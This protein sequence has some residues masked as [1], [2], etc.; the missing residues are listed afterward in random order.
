VARYVALLR[1]INVGG[2]NKVTMA[3]L[4]RV[5]EG[6]GHTAVRTYLQSGNVVFSSDAPRRTLEADVERLLDVEL[7][8]PV[9]VVVR[10]AGELRQV[11]AGAPDGFGAAAVHSDVVFLRSPLTPAA[12][13]RA[14]RL[15][16]GVDRAWPGRGVLYFTRLSAARSRSRMNSIVG[17]PEYRLMTIRNWSTTTGLLAL[18]DGDGDG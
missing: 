12:A 8:T 5:L 13:M 17:T 15:A 4:R 10:S 2:R 18:V 14:V 7:A 1:G 16:E 6:A 9:V 11:V 3:E